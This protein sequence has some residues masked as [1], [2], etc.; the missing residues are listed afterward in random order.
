MI[1]KCDYTGI[2]S[3]IISLNTL[4]IESLCTF[5]THSG[6]AFFHFEMFSISFHW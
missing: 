2:F 1:I 6:E 5:N 3:S 4:C